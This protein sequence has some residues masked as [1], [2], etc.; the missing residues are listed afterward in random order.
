[1][2]LNRSH[3]NMENVRCSDGIVLCVSFQM[4]EAGVGS[5]LRRRVQVFADVISNQRTLTDL[6]SQLV[7]RKE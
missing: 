1:M 7:K 6:D 5:S 3:I 4:E 2:Y